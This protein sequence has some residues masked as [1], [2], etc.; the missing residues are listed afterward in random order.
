M[1][2]LRREGSAKLLRRT[3]KP[4]L[5]KRGEYGTSATITGCYV[6]PRPNH[7]PLGTALLPAQ[8]ALLA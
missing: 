8:P 1:P 4:N 2:S 6:W 7:E 5:S 3:R